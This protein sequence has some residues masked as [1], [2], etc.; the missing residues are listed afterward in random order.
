MSLAEGVVFARIHTRHG[1]AVEMTLVT[2]QRSVAGQLCELFSKAQEFN[3]P[4]LC[5]HESI[6]ETQWE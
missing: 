1:F 2:V 6:P 3:Q 5:C 4:D